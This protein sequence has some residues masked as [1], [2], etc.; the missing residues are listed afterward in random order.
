MASQSAYLRYKQDTSRIIYWIVGTSNTIIRKLTASGLDGELHDDLK[1][2]NTSGGVT[3]AGLVALAKL[4]ARHITAT[5]PAILRLLESTIEERTAAY[6][7][8]QKV[9]ASNP[10]RDIEKS[11]SSHKAFIDAL[12]Q[13]FD[14]L[15]GEVA[16]TAAN[17]SESKTDSTPAPTETKKDLEELLLSNAFS[18]LDLHDD[19][20]GDYDS[21]DVEEPHSTTSKAAVRRKQAK[22]GK[23]KKGKKGKKPMKG[24][25]GPKLQDIPLEEYRII[26]DPDGT[27]TEYCMARFELKRMMINL[28]LVQASYWREVAYDGLNSAVAGA[29]CKVSH[30]M[31]RRTAM[32]MFLEFPE[33]H[34]SFN[35]V[36]NIYHGDEEPSDPN[37]PGTTIVKEHLFLYCYEDLLDFVVDF[38][39][40]RSGKPTKRM[41]KQIKDWDPEFDLQTATHNE[42]L[43]WRRRYTI[44]WLYDLVNV[45]SSG[46][47]MD[48]NK[49]ACLEDVDWSLNKSGRIYGLEEFAA[50][51]TSL[52]MQKPGTD[53]CNRILPHHIFQLQGI[54]DSMTV[55][56]GWSLGILRGDV[57][58]PPPLNFRPKRDVD[59]F[60]DRKREQPM[61]GV[62]G[63]VFAGVDI[64]RQLREA[65]KLTE[66]ASRGLLIVIW[67]VVRDLL[68]WLGETN[69]EAE[70]ANI[71]PSRFSSTNRNGLWEYSPYLCGV[72][73]AESL[74][75][76]YLLGMRL[77]D[78][79]P[80]ITYTQHLHNM[81]V[82]AKLITPVP[83][84]N[85][86]S[87]LFGS[88]F[89]E[90]GKP[91]TSN[92]DKSL[93]HHTQHSE[94]R[95]RAFDQLAS[96]LSDKLA[97]RLD[98][99]PKSPFVHDVHATDL[100]ALFRV[101]STLVTLERA[102]WELDRIPVAD[103]PLGSGLGIFRI[104]TTNQF[105]NRFTGKHEFENT[106]LVERYKA[107]E[108]A[109]PGNEGVLDNI[110]SQVHQQ[111]VHWKPIQRKAAA[112]PL[113]S[114]GKMLSTWGDIPGGTDGRLLRPQRATMMGAE[115][116]DEEI[117]A[118]IKQ[119][120]VD[121]IC[122]LQR[123]LSS[124]N[125]VT[126]TIRT[127][128]QFGKIEE[129]LRGARNPTYI[130]VYE[131]RGARDLAQKRQELVML[132]L[133]GRDE[134]LLRILADVFQNEPVS[135]MAFRHHLYWEP[136]D[137][138]I[139]VH[140]KLPQTTEREDEEKEFKEER[141]CLE[142]AC[143][144]M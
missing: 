59:V 124:L 120:I 91:P 99:K 113:T 45:F 140:E 44:N 69:D 54:V 83:L 73:L 77:W 18:A 112:K 12:T 50:F 89:Y 47:K 64:L 109:K 116:N 104:S 27:M 20:G 98:G 4:I 125:F 78:L 2:Q 97:R 111:S 142:R 53:V 95:S 137:A 55:S 9:T 122:G 8:Y 68:D 118:Y 87:N 49:H 96:K 121:D 35:N 67:D 94:R 76:M 40:T 23:A 51:I 6:S 117:L 88:C 82:Q 63:G 58:R 7:V 39:K 123:P 71:P 75:I 32:T 107:F 61:R 30:A 13:T 103:I 119:D 57:I 66:V 24:V 14:V 25:D 11:N 132:A 3:I 101:Q 102:G 141:K 52:A 136:E 106:E 126:F 19:D 131:Q 70:L 10:D 130:K 92:Y 143:R 100:N 41:L 33:G 105:L 43:E 36:I 62:E 15:G 93:L 65:G 135:M 79:L 28:R 110:M 81:L 138:M 22:A 37:F 21:D 133:K 127:L 90:D 34:G 108:R 48:G 42:R 1:Q 74:Q 129:K 29:L 139:N 5:P 85:I 84:L 60:L 134:G 16:L 144:M 114:I 86:F 115:I 46:V 80:E 31:V 26:H 128:A 56:R 72:G 17:L 38:Q